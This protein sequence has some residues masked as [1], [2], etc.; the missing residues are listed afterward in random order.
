MI[1]IEED[2]QINTKQIEPMR[3]YKK[4]YSFNNMPIAKYTNKED[5]QNKISEYF[6]Q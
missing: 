6:N 1:E 3:E 2:K 5:L 4:T